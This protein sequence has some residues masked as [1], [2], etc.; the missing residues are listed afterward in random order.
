MHLQEILSFK[1]MCISVERASER[2]KEG[3]EVEQAN[4]SKRE[5]ERERQRT[6]ATEQRR[7]GERGKED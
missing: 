7:R 6:N 2:E 3:G 1:W 4:E 5:R